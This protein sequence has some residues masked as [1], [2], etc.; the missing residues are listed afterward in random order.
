MTINDINFSQIYQD[1]LSIAGRVA[2]PASSWD[3]R[4]ESMAKRCSDPEDDY[5]KTFLSLMDLSGA[6]TLL[7]VGCGPGTIGLPLANKLSHVY[8]MD[9]SAG[10]INVAQ[11]RAEQMKL[12]NVTFIQKSWDESW[13]DIPACDIVVASRSTLVS[14]MAA[15]LK[16]LH[17]KA[18]LRVYTTHTVTPHFMDARILKA[19][20]RESLGL[21]TYIYAINILYQMGI[22]PELTYI[23]A[24]AGQMNTDSFDAFESSVSWSLGPLTARER[25][26]LRQYYQQVKNSAQPLVSSVRSWAFISWAK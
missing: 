23:H 26:G 3:E 6:E 12:S 25:E 14:D 18:R 5:T 21:P 22:N 16:Q 24:K 19:I 8:G 7:D 17:D 2:K 15:A 13:Q 4:A 9:Y 10:M 20:G 1:H 11:R